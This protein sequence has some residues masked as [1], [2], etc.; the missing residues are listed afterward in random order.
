MSSKNFSRAHELLAILLMITISVTGLT[1]QRMPQ[2]GDSWSSGQFIP[3]ASA[4]EETQTLEKEVDQ[5]VH[6]K[7]KIKNTGNL[8]TA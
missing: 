3:M 2:S 5:F 7:A 1:F 6:F 4:M 8:E